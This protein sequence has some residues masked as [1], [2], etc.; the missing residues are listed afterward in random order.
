METQSLPLAAWPSAQLHPL[1]WKS[2][3]WS[4]GSLPGFSLCTLPLLPSQSTTEKSL[5]CLL[6]RCTACCW[7]PATLHTTDHHTSG[8]NIQRVLSPIYCLLIQ[9]ILH[10]FPYEDPMG[11][12]VK[13]LPR[14]VGN[15]LSPANLFS[16]LEK[17]IRLVKYDFPFV[18]PYWLLP[19]VF[20]SLSL[21][22]I[23]SINCS[24]TL[25]RTEVMLKSL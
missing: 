19:I 12:N 24:I 7:P 18:N 20:F 25:P 9:P 14:Q 22:S 3:S 23:S 4:P 6:L 8:L 17:V 10:Q 11:Y 13:M 2:G 21:K 15:V 16:L 5:L 1:Q